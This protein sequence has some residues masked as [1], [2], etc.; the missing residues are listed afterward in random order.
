MMFG[1]MCLRMIRPS[2]APMVWAASMYSFSRTEST[3]PR[4]RR[5]MVSQA[6]IPSRRR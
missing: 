6:V 2:L 5:A 1:R 3:W 4:D